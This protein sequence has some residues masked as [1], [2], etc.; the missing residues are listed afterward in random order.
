MREIEFRGKRTKNGKWVTGYYVANR[1]EH[2]IVSPQ[3]M[4][5]YYTVIPETIGQY[6]GLKDENG[7][8]I[9]EGDVI[10]SS[11]GHHAIVEWEKEGR[12]LGFTIENERKIL[13]VNREPP[14]VIVGNIHDNPEL[15]T[16]EK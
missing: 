10:L 1:L 13:Y 5:A 6:T 12:F 16:D 7:A 4:N 9:F 8:K 14:V 15:L 3:E 11:L 2:C